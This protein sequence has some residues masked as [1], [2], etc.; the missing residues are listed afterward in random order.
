M[1]EAGINDF[2]FVLGY[3]GTKIKSYLEKDYPNINKEY[4][5]QDERNGLGDAILHTKEL[6][7]NE[8]EIVI[9]LGDTIVD[10]DL[11]NFLAQPNSCLAI[12]KVN[13]PR[14]FGVVEKNKNDVIVRV[15]EKP[16]IP[17]SNLAIVGLYKINEVNLLIEALEAL[18]NIIQSDDQELHLTNG[19][20]E[21]IN[22]GVK[23]KTYEV[24]NWYDCG[25]KNILLE[26]NRVLLNRN[27]SDVGTQFVYD[28]SIIIPPV[29]FGKSC[30]FNNSIIGPNVTLG[31]NVTITNSL[32]K[33]S[34][35]GNYVEIQR[36]V[37]T[38]SVIGNDAV[39]KG[40]SQSLNIGDNNEIDF[41]Q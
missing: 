13:D 20:Q 5:Y 1:L 24:S 2:V 32:L 38:K 11:K 12:Q 15:V 40:P 35:L 14:Q 18:E 4:V 8:D 16:T 3:L 33:D 7:K 28:H 23:I 6:I 19:I 10:L 26:T 9:L 27:I 34:I 39:I 17:K 22:Q 30:K 31:D 36:A 41:T 21:L 29:V 25:K 37:L